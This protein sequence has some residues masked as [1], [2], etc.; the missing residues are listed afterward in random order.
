MLFAIYVIN[1]CVGTQF[2]YIVDGE[3]CERVSLN[4][5]ILSKNAEGKEKSECGVGGPG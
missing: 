4:W 3:R 2:V 1:V 5:Q